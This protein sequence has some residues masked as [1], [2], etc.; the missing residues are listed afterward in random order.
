MLHDLDN[1]DQVY[2]EH[3]A[4]SKK[5]LLSVVK[6]AAAKFKRHSTVDSQPVQSFSQVLAN[7]E[8]VSGGQ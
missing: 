3:V 7:D 1:V 5:A 4:R 6:I 8:P 2:R